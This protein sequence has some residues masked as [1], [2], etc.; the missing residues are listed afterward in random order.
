MTSHTHP[1]WQL[2]SLSDVLARMPELRAMYEALPGAEDEDDDEDEDEAAES[3]HDGPMLVY[4]AGDTEL[5]HA[6]WRTI[7]E[8][9]GTR[10]IAVDGNLRFS[11]TCAPNGCVR[12]NLHCDALHGPEFLLVGGTVHARQFAYLA[13]EDHEVVQRGAPLRL[14]TPIVFA[15]FHDV[16]QLQLAPGTVLDILCDYNDYRAMQVRTPHFFWNAS[17]FA[18]KPELCHAADS[19]YSD[20]PYWNIDAFRACADRGES[21]FIDGFDSASLPL[22]AQGDDLIRAGDL[23]AAFARYRQAAMLSP[24][25]SPGWRDMGMALYHAGAYAQALPLF[26]RAAACFPPRHRKLPQ[27]AADHAALCAVRLRQLDL[28]IELATSSIEATR[29]NPMDREKRYL[30]YRVRGE[31][32]MLQD[33]WQGARE[34]LA[35]AAD[36]GWSKPAPHWLLGR[37]LHHVGE[38]RQA[39]Q[40]QAKTLKVGSQ[41]YAADFASH[42]CADFACAAP[43]RVDWDG[44]DT[45][46]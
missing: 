32:R 22:Q 40:C 46:P 21:Y 39:S 16:A 8:Q 23:A 18:L 20:A 3:A 24:A 27:R 42:A 1:D 25:W 7:R 36:W 29:N 15:W 4:F 19:D 34:D 14:D 38:H 28:A 11:G 33:D 44:A 37:V 9:A 13:A 6:Q 30:P 45:A 35:I 5:D 41:R 2:L 31:A 12:D 10:L 26:R 43:V 17:L